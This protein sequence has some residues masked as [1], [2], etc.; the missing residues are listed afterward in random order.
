[1]WPSFYV[2]ILTLGLGTIQ[3]ACHSWRVTFQGCRRLPS[4]QGWRDGCVSRRRDKGRCAGGRSD[5]KGAKLRPV[6]T[7][8][9]GPSRCY[10]SGNIQL[11]FSY[12]KTSKSSR[13]KP[14]A[15]SASSPSKAQDAWVSGVVLRISCAI[16][17]VS[18]SASRRLKA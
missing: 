2:H 3:G 17:M 4:R 8:S 1:M 11:S 18:V 16:L 5:R 15:R 13:Y 14:Y 9:R 10:F 6:V 12:L 7:L